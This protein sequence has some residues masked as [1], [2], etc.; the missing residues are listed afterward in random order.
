MRR[1][2][3]AIQ[4]SYESNDMRT[5]KE[6]FLFFLATC[7]IIF[8]YLLATGVFLFNIG[9]AFRSVQI[10]HPQPA[11]SRGTSNFS[12]LNNQATKGGLI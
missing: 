4:I 2:S 7:A 1:A 3:L 11:I 9:E 8:C 6:S 12:N 10:R 5:I